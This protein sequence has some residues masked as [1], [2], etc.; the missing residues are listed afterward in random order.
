MQ[1]NSSAL[2]KSLFPDLEGSGLVS[3]Y[4]QPVRVQHPGAAPRRVVLVDS[5]EFAV[6]FSANDEK[7]VAVGD[8]SRPT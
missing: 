6:A 3:G 2:G 1:T 5:V 4:G 7:G 8:A